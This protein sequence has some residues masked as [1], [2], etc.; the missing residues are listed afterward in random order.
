MDGHESEG[1][2]VRVALLAAI[3][4]L[5]SG[6]AALPFAFDGV[7]G[8]VAIYQRYEDRQAQKDQ[9]DAIRAQTNEIIKLREAIERRPLR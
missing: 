5:T 6:C 8:G 4:L 9:T 1:Q 3:V 2:T 7:L